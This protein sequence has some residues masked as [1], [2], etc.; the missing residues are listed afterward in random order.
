MPPQ[1]NKN[2]LYND[3]W[4]G[5][6]SQLASAIGGQDKIT[7]EIAQARKTGKLCLSGASMTTLPDEM[8]DLRNDL[9]DKY[10]GDM[11][12]QNQLNSHEKAWQCYGEEMLTMVRRLVNNVFTYFLHIDVVIENLIVIFIR[13]IHFLLFQNIG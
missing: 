6:E 13:I 3:P 2:A 12:D 5:I 9:L 1:Q 4:K 10:N 7:F 8:F 11:D